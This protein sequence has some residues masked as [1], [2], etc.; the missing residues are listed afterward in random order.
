MSDDLREIQIDIGTLDGWV[1]V[2]K[3]NEDVLTLSPSQAAELGYQVIRGALDL[4]STQQ[5]KDLALTASQLM[6]LVDD[7]RQSLNGCPRCG[8]GPYPE[9]KY[10]DGDTGWLHMP[11]A[12]AANGAA[13]EENTR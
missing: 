1:Y 9:T 4:M 12:P 10:P 8:D 3:G 13:R 2:T 6:N 5:L 7:Y 11:D